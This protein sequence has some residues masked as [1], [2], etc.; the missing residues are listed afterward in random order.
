MSDVTTSRI[1]SRRA[2]AH[3]IAKYFLLHLQAEVQ[4]PD[5]VLQEVYKD[6]PVREMT[7]EMIEQVRMEFA[8]GEEEALPEYNLFKKMVRDQREVQL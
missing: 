6:L 1:A 2:V 5:E 7:K 8:I 4:K 3:L